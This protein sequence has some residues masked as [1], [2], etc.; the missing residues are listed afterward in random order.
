MEL[1]KSD[2]D[3]SNPQEIF[4]SADRIINTI[5]SLEK[6]LEAILDK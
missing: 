6:E 3:F 4:D 5:K 1:N 2:L